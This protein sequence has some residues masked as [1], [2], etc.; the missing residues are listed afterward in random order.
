MERE[1]KT[2]KIGSHDLVLNAY[3]TGREANEL[4]RVLFGSVNVAVEGDTT[5]A[6]NISGAVLVQ[7]E[8]KAIEMLVVSLDG[9]AENVLARVLDLP[10][11]EYAQVVEAV[12]A[13]R[14]PFEKEK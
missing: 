3:V 10:E 11:A 5:K 13:I 7:Q 12:N 9:S 14:V 4:K 8:E 6:S 2:V 1:K